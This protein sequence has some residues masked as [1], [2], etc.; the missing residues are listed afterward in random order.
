MHCPNCGTKASA[1]QKFCRAC[2]FG[3]DKVEQLIAEQKNVD[4]DQTMEAIGGLSGDRLRKIEK[5]AFRAFVGLGGVLGGL[6]LWGIIAKLMIQD[7]KIIPGVILL[8]VIA[9]IA[10]A[11]FWA[12]M[13]G[14]QRK[15]PA[16]T[17]LNERQH[18]TAAEETA[19]MLSEPSIEISSSVT[20]QTTAR[21]EEK[22]E[23]RR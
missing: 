14:T 9:F 20:E 21:L 4:S 15:K 8:M 6:G 22:L 17:Q 1:G 19:K 12:Y 18:L 10:L 16:S 11:M 3:L 5:W 13:V 23:S 7:G 2:G